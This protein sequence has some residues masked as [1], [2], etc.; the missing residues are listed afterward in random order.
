MNWR[1]SFHDKE[2]NTKNVHGTHQFAQVRNQVTIGV[3][4]AMSSLS[5][6]LNAQKRM[7]YQIVK[8]ATC[9]C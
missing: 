6:I 9:S 4:L 2:Y 8:N 5:V 7:S 3:K 1:N